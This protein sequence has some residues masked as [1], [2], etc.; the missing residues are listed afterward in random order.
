MHQE[1]WPL[2]WILIQAGSKSSAPLRPA[3]LLRTCSSSCAAGDG[4]MV[5]TCFPTDNSG[6]M[7][8][9]LSIIVLL[10]WIQITLVVNTPQLKSSQQSRTSEPLRRAPPHTLFWSILS[11]I[12][13]SWNHDNLYVY[14]YCNIV[15]HHHH[16]HH[17]HH[18]HLTIHNDHFYNNSAW[19]PYSQYIPCDTNVI[20][21]LCLL[22]G[23]EGLRDLLQFLGRLL[24]Q[25]SIGLAQAALPSHPRQ[26]QL[27]GAGDRFLHGAR[28]GVGQLEMQR[29]NRQREDVIAMF[30]Q[31]ILQTQQGEER[32]C[33][34]AEDF[35][36]AHPGAGATPN[37]AVLFSSFEDF[38][39]EGW[40]P[41]PVFHWGPVG[42]A[43]RQS[44]D[45]DQ[46]DRLFLFLSPTIFWLDI[47]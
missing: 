2:T 32:H 9:L 14:M 11:Q 17:H 28:E 42:Q 34:A 3:R 20:P 8:W 24:P 27:G 33:G 37:E 30:L 41:G 36:M 12:K 13:I 7:W 45:W 26:A 1:F 46:L 4:W 15:N 25:L 18:L 22:K 31:I 21:S 39:Q 5:S 19:Y 6:D 29:Q 44:E 47:S 43:Q 40:L 10:G 16:H 35:G 38:G 23:I